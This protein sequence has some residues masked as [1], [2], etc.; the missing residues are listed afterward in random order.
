MRSTNRFVLSSLALLFVFSGCQRRARIVP[1]IEEL[2]FNDTPLSANFIGTLRRGDRIR[3]EGVIGDPFTDIDGFAFVSD[4]PIHVDF[5]LFAPRDLDVCLFDPA[6][7]QTVACFATANDPERGG[8]DVFG[9]GLEFHLTVEA[10]IEPGCFP[11]PGTPYTLEL[12]VGS[13]FAIQTEAENSLAQGDLGSFENEDASPSISGT[14][15]GFEAA[16]SETEDGLE[17]NASRTRAP[18]QYKQAKGEESKAPS[19]VI[20]E[21]IEQIEVGGESIL[22]HTVEIND[23]TR[24]TP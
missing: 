17:Q 8:V 16:R 19:M 20:E 15:I 14:V 4:G 10:C 3:I 24:T 12:T 2:E 23:L 18:S 22:L 1:V 11:G 6:L 9:D 7:D 5:E 13:L 21:R